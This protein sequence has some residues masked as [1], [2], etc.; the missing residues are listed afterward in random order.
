MRLNQSFDDGQSQADP[1]LGIGTRRPP[2][3]ESLEHVGENRWGDAWSIVGNR[4]ND[5]VPLRYRTDNDRRA[6]WGVACRVLEQIAQNPID[7]DVV[8]RDRR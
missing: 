3:L 8:D 7:R 6:S 2:T 5:L 1:A 4:D